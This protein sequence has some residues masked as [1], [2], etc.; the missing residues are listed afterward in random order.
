[1]TCQFGWSEKL[2]YDVAG[3]EFSASGSE[4]VSDGST[5]EEGGRLSRKRKLSLDE[6]RQERAAGDHPLQQRFKELSTRLLRKHTG[7]ASGG[8]SLTCVL[9]F[10]I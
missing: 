2:P 10:Q 8:V 7:E 6:R 1:M 4:S 9:S 3:Q 5:E